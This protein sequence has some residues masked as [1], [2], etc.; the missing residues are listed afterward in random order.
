MEKS[1]HVLSYEKLMMNDLKAMAGE[2]PV[3]LD[4]DRKEAIIIR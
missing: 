1:F 3:I 2:C 4:G